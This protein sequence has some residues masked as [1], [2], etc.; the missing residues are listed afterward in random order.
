M[1]ILISSSATS[2]YFVIKCETSDLVSQVKTSI[3]AQEGIQT[4]EQFLSFQ[5][6]PMSDFRRLDEYGIKDESTL[7]LNLRT[8]GGPEKLMSRDNSQVEQTKTMK[9]IQQ[10]KSKSMI[11]DFIRDKEKLLPTDFS[12]V[13]EL[14]ELYP[15]QKK[16]KQQKYEGKLLL[17]EESK[18]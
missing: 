6:K 2:C 10:K 7:T 15:A 3:E 12:S 4:S 1:Q 5:V 11:E 14:K 17:G 16:L 13:D 8:R 9:K 18:D